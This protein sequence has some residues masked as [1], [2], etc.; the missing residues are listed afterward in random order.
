MIE[1]ECDGAVATLVL[2]RPD[3]R[4]AL[5]LALIAELTAAIDKVGDDESIRVV[6][7]GARGPA[8]CAG[9]DLDRKS[10]V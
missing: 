5:S 4:N 10:V 2:N 1:S 3:R 9:H 6:V 7:L 8:F